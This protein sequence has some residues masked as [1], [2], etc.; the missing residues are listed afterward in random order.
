MKKLIFSLLISAQYVVINPLFAME[1]EEKTQLIGK[2]PT[3]R[4]LDKGECIHIIAPSGAPLNAQHLP[5][6]KDLITQH[7]FQAY[8]PESA[9]NKEASPYKYYANTHDERAKHLM[10]ALTGE[11]KALWALRGGFGAIEVVTRLE[12]AEK[13]STFSKP[14]TIKPII[15]FSDVTSLHLLASTWGWPSLHG[16]VGYGDELF[17]STQTNVNKSVQLSS[18]FSILGGEQ[19]E[20]DY[21]FEVLHP[22]NLL[23]DIPIFGSVLGGNLSLIEAHK[24]TPT[25]LKGKNQFVFFEDTPEDPK[26]LSRR[27]MGLV[28]SGIFD[29]AKGI[30]VGSNPLSGFDTD[31]ETKDFMKRFFQE[32][33]LSQGINIPVVYSSRFGHGEHND[34][35]PFGTKASLTLNG[36]TAVLKVSVNESAY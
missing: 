19:K 30:I 18:L 16:P 15:G 26:R 25:E 20:L 27:L 33:L 22:G 11:G 14:E 29:E 2:S 21:S 34:V 28:S 10:D 36:D 3:W 12:R 6:V 23:P 9:L 35:L 5:A 4:F 31:Q 8:I 17:A 24:G 7:G 1:N 13:Q 32:E